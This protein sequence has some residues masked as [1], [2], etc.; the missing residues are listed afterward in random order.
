MRVGEREGQGERKEGER[1]KNVGGRI[2]EGK[3]RKEKG[4][5]RKF[6]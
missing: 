3:S 5:N 4:E 2:G 1:K 6:A